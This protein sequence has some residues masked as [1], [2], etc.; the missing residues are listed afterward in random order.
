MEME[1]RE[2]WKILLERLRLEINLFRDTMLHGSK[3]D[4][5]AGSHKIE[6]YVY[7]YEILVEEAERMQ[8]PLLRKLAHQPSGILDALYEKWWGRGGSSYTEL[9]AYIKDELEVFSVCAADGGKGTG[10]G[11]KS[12]KAA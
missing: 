9:R 5:Y 10:H 11:E 3:A 8:E 7:L 6:M 4:I 1:E 2:L 12:D